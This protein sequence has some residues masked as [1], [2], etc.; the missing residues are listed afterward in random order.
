MRKYPASACSVSLSNVSRLQHA[1]ELF[2]ALSYPLQ[3][4]TYRCV[5][6]HQLIYE[7]RDL[8]ANSV[9]RSLPQSPSSKHSRSGAKEG[10]SVIGTAPG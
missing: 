6:D 10:K 7:S 8:P 1:D 9:G 3:Y 4:G 2:D 5:P